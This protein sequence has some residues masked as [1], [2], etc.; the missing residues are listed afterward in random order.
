ME[1]NFT[2]PYKTH[3]RTPPESFES[4]ITAISTITINFI[5]IQTTHYDA[6]NFHCEVKMFP[7]QETCGGVKTA[8]SRFFSRDFHLTS[9][10]LVIMCVFV[11][12]SG[13]WKT[14]L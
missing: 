5:F 1:R 11:G 10:K 12:P 7:P 8:A 2:R 6:S 13:K 3:L 9:R 4:N 14:A